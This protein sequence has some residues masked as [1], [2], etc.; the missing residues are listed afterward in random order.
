MKMFYIILSRLQQR[1]CSL[2]RK[3]VYWGKKGFI[4]KIHLKMRNIYQEKFFKKEKPLSLEIE[5]PSIV[6]NIQCT[7]YTVHCICRF[8][9]IYN[10]HCGEISR[11]SITIYSVHC[12]LFTLHYTVTCEVVIVNTSLLYSC[13]VYDDNLKRAQLYIN[14]HCTLYTVHC[15]LY[16]LQC[17]V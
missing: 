17:T 13:I 16:T 6:Y 15:T 7:V 8:I 5:T 2:G 9:S 12:T 3:G 10:A 4:R 11:Y 1:L 14:V